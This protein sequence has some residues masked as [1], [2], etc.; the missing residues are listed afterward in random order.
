[1]NSIPLI[2]LS[3]LIAYAI[4]NISPSIMLAKARGI[5]I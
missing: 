5:D 4:G 2:L 3:V 1:M